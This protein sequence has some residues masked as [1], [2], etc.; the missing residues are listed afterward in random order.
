MRAALGFVLLQSF[1]ATAELALPVLA[2]GL[3]I[4][5]WRD[6][7]HFAGGPL[8]LEWAL[9]ALFGGWLLAAAFGLDARRSLMLS[10][11][12]LGFGLLLIG[13][14]RRPPRPGDA[15]LLL[16]GL[17]A[18]AT[19]QA[20][21][22]LAAASIAHGA[23][24][25]AITRTAD[26]PW[27]VVPNDLLWMVCLWPW[28]WRA[29]RL[30]PSGWARTGWT[31]ALLVQASAV[32]GAHSRL[33]WLCALVA[34]AVDRTPHWRRQLLLVAL[35]LSLLLAADALSGG[36]LAAK[37]LASFGARA[38]L[39]SA[40]WQMFL[41]HP[42]LGVGPHNFVLAYQ[43]L[44]PALAI[45]PRLTPWPHSLPLELLAELGILGLLFCLIMLQFAARVAAATAQRDFPAR[46]VL[47]GLGVAAGFEASTLRIWWWV[48][49]ALILAWP[50]LQ[51][52]SR[53]IGKDTT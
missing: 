49:L 41:Q 29:L 9:L 50:W 47:A 51:T 35:S 27:L 4:A 48:L 40:A 23:S 39:W 20:G 14:L 37:G 19:L 12:M 26:L 18:A 34:L 28:L 32:W 16:A 17:A 46:G 33:L 38:Q 1:A 44:L 53:P 6:E 31:T 25:A 36:A 43:A 42:L 22:W 24:P 2:L 8:A 52:S 11:P 13:L 7:L 15:H 30:A 3:A 10:V 5:A 21:Q 45:D